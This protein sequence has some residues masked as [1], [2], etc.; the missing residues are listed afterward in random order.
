MQLLLKI[1]LQF[2][3]VETTLAL[4]WLT[5][6]DLLVY[7]APKRLLNILTLKKV[8]PET[9]LCA[10]NLIST[11]FITRIVFQQLLVTLCTKMQSMNS[12]FV[13][14]AQ[15]LFQAFYSVLMIST[16]FRGCSTGQYC[17]TIALSELFSEFCYR[18]TTDP[19]R[20]A[21]GE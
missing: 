20:C 18:D 19:C 8:I 5:C 11:F 7:L 3:Q 9:R 16:S 2:P 14:Y 10:Q 6:L 12:N 4:F 15:I 21:V 1:K 17:V 13:T